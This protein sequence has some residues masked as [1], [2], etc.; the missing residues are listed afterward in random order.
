[1][2]NVALVTSFQQMLN[3]LPTANMMK[4]KAGFW[5]VSKLEAGL[6]KNSS[7]SN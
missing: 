7:S 1:M 2:L 3:T 4:R 6:Y 5:E